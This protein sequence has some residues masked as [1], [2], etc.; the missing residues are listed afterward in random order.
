MRRSVDND[1]CAPFY[2]G[3]AKLPTGIDKNMV[4][5][6]DVNKDRGSDACQGDS[7]GP[8]ILESNYHYSVIGVTS[9][10]QACGSYVPGIYTAVYP[11]LD[12]IEEQVWL[13]NDTEHEQ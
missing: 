5:V 12:W 2:T 8:L 10:G 1:E 11:Y 7:G 3:F 13:N 9:F 4:C 6:I